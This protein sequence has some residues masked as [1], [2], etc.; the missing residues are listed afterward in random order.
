MCWQTLNKMP[1]IV[2][3]RIYIV[4]TK[5]NTFIFINF[6]SIMKYLSKVLSMFFVGSMLLTVG[7]AKDDIRDLN[8]KINNVQTA[9]DEQFAEV[10]KNLGAT[11]NDLDKLSKDIETNKSDLNKLTE[12]YEKF[13]KEVKEANYPKQIKD[14]V[15]NFTTEVETLKGQD[16]AFK[17]QLGSLEANINAALN[18]VK[19]DLTAA[20]QT[21]KNDLEK[22]LADYKELTDKK[23]A[24]LEKR[25]ADAEE[26]MN[27]IQAQINELSDKLA[28]LIQNITFIPE[29]TDGLATAVRVVGPKGASLTATTLTA[30]FEVTP[31]SAVNVLAEYGC[32]AVEPLKTRAEVLR[33]ER[34]VVEPIEDQSGRVKVTAFVH[35]MPADFNSYAFTLN[36]EVEGNNVAAS[37]FVYIHEGDAP[38]YQYILVTEEGNES[39]E[40]HPNWDA[41]R[42]ALVF[43][44]KWTK[45]PEEPINALEGYVYKLTNDGGKTF[46]TL[47][48]I[49]NKFGMS[50]NAL[51][52]THDVSIPNE[53][54]AKFVKATADATIDMAFDNEYDMY[55]YVNEEAEVKFFANNNAFLD[56]VV[57]AYYKV[58]GSKVV[59]NVFTIEEVGDL[60][61]LSQNQD[62]EYK[63]IVFAENLELDM[64]RYCAEDSENAPFKAI[65]P[66]H[67]VSIEGNNAIVKNIVVDGADEVGLFGFVR[68]NIE[69]LTVKNI[70]ANGNHWVGGIAGCVAGTIT[71]CHVEDAIINAQPRLVDNEYDDGDK[72]GGIVGYSMPDTEGGPSA[73]IVGCSVKHAKI[74]AFRDLGGIVGAMNYGDNL[75]TNSVEDV[76]LFAEQRNSQTPG[77]YK[78]ANIGRIL[79]RDVLLKWNQAE[80]VSNTATDVDLRIRY[81][82]GAEVNVNS[83]DAKENTLEISTANGLAWFSQNVENTK[84]YN[85]ENVKLVRDI[86][87]EEKLCFE[88]DNV[89]FVGI[90]NYASRRKFVFDGMGYTIRNFKWDEERKNIA[91]FDW[92]A[93]DIKNVKMENVTLK[94]RGRVAPIAAQCW[95]HID[96]CHVNG[97]D[98]KVYQN[99]EDGDKLGGIVAQMQADGESGTNNLITNCSVSN[100]EIEGYRD[101]G[102]LAGH[103]DLKEYDNSNKFF[104]VSI[105]VNQ[106]FE[107][108]EAGHYPFK[109]E[110]EVVGRIS[111]DS[112]AKTPED[113]D[114]VDIFQIIDK[115]LYRR[116]V[117]TPNG[118]LRLG[119]NGCKPEDNAAALWKFAE[120]Y[121]ERK[122]VFQAADIKLDGQWTP[123]G[124]DYNNAFRGV[125]NGNGKSIEGLLIENN[126]T[127]PSGLFGF[128][129]GTLTGIK[130]VKPIIYGSHWAGAVVAVM[131]GSVSNCEVSGGKVILAP[132]W[133]DTRYDDGDK[134]GALVG[135]L[136]ASGNGTDKVYNNTVKNVTVK[137]YR[138]VAALVGCANNIDLMSGNTIQDCSIVVDQVTFSYPANDPKNPNIGMLIGDLRAETEAI[139]ES[140]LKNISNNTIKTSTLGQVVDKGDKVVTE[141][142]ANVN[143]GS[144]RE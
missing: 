5:P 50:E 38:E 137:A 87:F 17:K 7:C 82:I 19:D 48:E 101:L 124:S 129:V 108:Y 13:E 55:K 11:Q 47:A 83:F 103:A 15:D 77:Y 118:Q 22:A 10:E 40:S 80:Y 104:N 141:T 95:G 144:V 93:G 122:D 68:G 42:D 62:C 94:G 120:E 88:D 92:F 121:K 44:T 91:L 12:A 27:D 66:I 74:T 54:H 63:K 30:V 133:N 52:V 61:W 136:A 57:K 100:A 75:K 132:S 143:V 18:K 107:G 123:I 106:L 79:G 59:D 73:T 81:A 65:S 37:D 67:V 2:S 3:A 28:G 135:Y 16:E 102:A 24:D 4:L 76:K 53:D 142:I 1:D 90:S 60:Y 117:V 33:G 46:Y 99:A 119:Y 85:F 127:S 51:A 86:D 69:N 8:N 26:R 125:Y 29:Y 131:Y 110:H 98:I 20:D 140:S 56:D 70:T 134:A 43:E 72:A 116:Y 109:N 45:A 6:Y 126:A 105:W 36:V 84:Y 111:L 112:S 138:D 39:I 31:A 89:K 41:E 97:L 64:V 23:I 34:L 139:K 35:N 21:I 114:G 58:V 14:A 115:E 78:D 113:V 9:M 32:V 96:N 130:I 49:E 25:I 71:N 128:V